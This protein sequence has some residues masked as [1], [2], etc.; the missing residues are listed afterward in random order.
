MRE[1]KFR[2][3]SIN[4]GKWIHG[5]LVGTDVIAGGYAKTWDDDLELDE[6]EKVDPET[7]GQFTGLRDANGVEIYEGDIVQNRRT[8]SAGQ[9]AY[10]VIWH[11]YGGEW[12]FKPFPLAGNKPFTNRVLL[13]DWEMIDDAEVVILGNI[14]DNP[15]LLED[16]Q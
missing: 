10:K 12:G 2:G 7:V 4:N 5:S 3:K 9:A 13:E 14:Y 11:E 16:Q 15:E 8:S 1:I 6:W